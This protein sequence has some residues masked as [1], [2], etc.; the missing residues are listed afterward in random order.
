[1]SA[2]DLT[3][4]HHFFMRRRFF[5]FTLLNIFKYYLRMDGRGSYEYQP[6]DQSTEEFGS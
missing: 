6:I 5:T 1:M 2:E 3:D 4:Y